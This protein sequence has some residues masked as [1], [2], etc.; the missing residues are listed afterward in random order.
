[1]FWFAHQARPTFDSASVINRDEELFLREHPGNYRILNRFN[2]N[3]A[4]SMRVSDLWGY[5]ASVVRRYAEFMAWTQDEDPDKATQDVTFKWA[6]PLFSL[7]RLRYILLPQPGNFRSLEVETPPLPRVLLISKYRI[8][9]FRD[10]IF[11]ALRAPDF[12]PRVEAILENEPDPPP[13][14]TEVPG[15]AQ[16]VAETTDDLT[17]EADV[18]Q[19]AILLI[20]DVYTPSWRAVSMPGSIQSHYRLQ[21]ANYILRAVPLAAG[22]H[23]FRVEYFSPEFEIGKWISLVAT[24]LF[25]GAVWKFRDVR[26]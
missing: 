4:M 22:H 11:T 6:D 20:T 25:V 24:V 12:D 1:M 9:K 18:V 7:L 17:I 10:A 8:A 16:I 15:T 2:P 5:D 14:P 23:R 3:S 19:P 26:L 13:V 21:P